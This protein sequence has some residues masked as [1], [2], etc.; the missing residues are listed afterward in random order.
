MVMN[1]NP[2][3]DNLVGYGQDFW[4]GEHEYGDWE[5]RTGDYKSPAAY[6]LNGQTVS[7]PM[8]PPQRRRNPGSVDRL[9][10]QRDRFCFC[11]RRYPRLAQVAA[12]PRLSLS[13]QCFPLNAAAATTAATVL[14]P[15]KLA[16]RRVKRSVAP[17][18]G[19]TSFGAATASTDLRYG[20]AEGGEAFRLMTYEPYDT[21]DRMGGFGEPPIAGTTCAA[22]KASLVSVTTRGWIVS[23]ATE[24]GKMVVVM[25]NPE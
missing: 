22:L 1:I 6:Q 23:C 8:Y 15:A 9:S 24:I 11:R 19:T 13:S 2:V 17:T 7:T 16:H 12:A 10:R 25:G 14:I 21:N 18:S 20:S 3:D 4:T 5:H